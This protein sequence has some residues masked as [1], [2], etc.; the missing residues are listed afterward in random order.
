MLKASRKQAAARD[1]DSI[2][3]F[4][5]D[6]RT[7]KL[8]ITDADSKKQAKEDIPSKLIIILLSIKI[9]SINFCSTYQKPIA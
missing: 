3:G 7:G 9:Y 6:K 4:K 1:E 2:R 8:V 5:V